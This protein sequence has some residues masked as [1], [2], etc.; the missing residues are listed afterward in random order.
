MPLHTPEAVQVVAFVVDHVSVLEPPM[1]TLV[2]F[3]VKL[4]VGKAG[5]FTET[6]TDRLVVPP[7]P[8]HDKV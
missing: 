4:T 8:V 2:G 3:A 6:V 7:T 5:A 1:E